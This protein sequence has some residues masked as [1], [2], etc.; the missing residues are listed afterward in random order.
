M[1]SIYKVHGIEASVY[2]GLSLLIVEERTKI[3]SHQ[4]SCSY[5]VLEA[6]AATLPL[7]KGMG[8]A[9]RVNMGSPSLPVACGRRSG[10]HPQSLVYQF[11]PYRLI[12]KI[13]DRMTAV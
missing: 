6:S 11:F 2:I 9:T 10:G 12:F 7:K 13:P 8:A 4:N 5:F 1:K 3:C